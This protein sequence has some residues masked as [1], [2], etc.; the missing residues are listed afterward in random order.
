M[1]LAQAHN[2]NRTTV[3]RRPNFSV[4]VAV[5]VLTILLTFAASVVRPLV[6]LPP[7]N[8][9][10]NY[11]GD[12]LDQAA[13]QQINWHPADA[14]AFSEARRLDR[15]V[16]LFIGLAWSQTA[17][18]LDQEVLNTADV[19]N[20]LSHNFVCVRID[21]SEAPAWVSAYL[22]VSRVSLGIRP[23][24]Q[25]WALEPDGKLIGN[26]NR[27]LPTT[28]LAQSNF[29]NDL[30]SVHDF[31]TK[32]R[33]AG[34]TG[35]MERE[36]LADE[37]QIETNNPSATLDFAAMSQSI[38]DAAD[39][40]NGGFP[41]NGFQDL[42]P[43]AWEFLAQTGQT[44]TLRET[45]A[46][47]LRSPIV[48][49]LDG[50]FFNT[51]RAVDHSQ[52]EFDKSSITTANMAWMLSQARPFLQA[53]DDRALCD[54]VLQLAEQSLNTEFRGESGLVNTARIGDEQ[55]DGRSIRSSMNP[56]RMREALSSEDREWVRSHLGLRVETNPQMIPYLSG[57]EA[58]TRIEEVRAKFADKAPRPTFTTHFFMD[59]NGTVAARL[60]ETGRATNNV[61]LIRNGSDLFT[62]L[63]A[64]RVGDSV[65]HDLEV[66]GRSSTTLLDYLAYSDAALQD[67][68]SSGRVPSLQNGLAVLQRGLATY[69]GV[70]PGEFRVGL[71]PS[72]DLLPSAVANAQ[73]VDD[74]GES[75]S[76]KV[77]R[78][79]TSYGRLFIASGDQSDTGLS[80]IRTA[81][82]SEALLSPIVSTMGVSAASF[83][84]ACLALNDDNYA[85]AVGP[86]AQVLADQLY[87]TRPTKLV[88]AAIGPVR[89]DLAN[90][91][92]GLYVIKGGIPA[93]PYSLQEA[94]TLLPASLT[95]SQ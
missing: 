46:P 3:R 65:P 10:A 75:A 87:R 66:A 33:Q 14:K 84:C 78:L 25:I 20:Y 5:V 82:A 11:A 7:P 50:G 73:V 31:Y 71:P 2:R 92:A 38:N 47:T 22:P 40:K 94:Q 48:D 89:T 4:A 12:Y 37:A 24:F 28:R 59:V 29:L 93:G 51:A 26:I 53:S 21:G 88:A 70:M 74:L 57:P 39:T 86:D 35:A 13:S 54:Y 9:I 27:R 80:L 79:C 49:V 42:R 30:V 62:L 18:E 32:I 69:A 15:P 17:R 72:S 61:Q 58:L 85:I 83:A 6:P 95:P 16:L 43:Y 19:Q 76:A 23:R 81:F 34:E 8:P 45:L 90:R 68:L 67:Y 63:D 64:E 91:K 55:E 60:M 41:V 1:S 52:L 36:Q 77:V 56:K 44:K